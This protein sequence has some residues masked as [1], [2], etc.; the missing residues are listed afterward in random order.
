M[1]FEELKR[2]INIRETI[3]LWAILHGK[4]DEYVRA[5]S[6]EDN[7]LRR[8]WETMIEPEVQRECGTFWGENPRIPLHPIGY[9]LMERNGL[10]HQGSETQTQGETRE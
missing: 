7:N 10:L 1:N 6:S 9:A 8:Y 5:Y 2:A 4:Y 3:K